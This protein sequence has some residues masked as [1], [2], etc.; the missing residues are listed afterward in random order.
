MLESPKR[1]GP[2]VGWAKSTLLWCPALGLAHGAGSVLG[3]CQF[4]PSLLL[5][6]SPGSSEMLSRGL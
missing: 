1:H 2:I 4:S 5:S 6:S 3:L